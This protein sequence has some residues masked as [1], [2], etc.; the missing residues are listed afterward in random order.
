MPN[1]LLSVLVLASHIRAL[2]IL[3]SLVLMKLVLTEYYMYC[4]MNP[5]HPKNIKITDKYTHTH[6]PITSNPS[7]HLHPLIPSSLFITLH[8][9]YLHLLSTP[10]SIF[11][12]AFHFM[13]TPLPFSPSIPPHTTCTIKRCLMAW[14]II[15]FQILQKAA[16]IIQ[17]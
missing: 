2:L 7:L 17:T 10:S 14:M 12:S 6:T 1:D 3:T 9:T 4:F 13:T 8:P 16:N 5:L 11:Y 15:T